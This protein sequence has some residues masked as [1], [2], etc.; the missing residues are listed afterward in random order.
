VAGETPALPKKSPRLDW[1]RL[2]RG[3]F[4]DKLLIRRLFILVLLTLAPLTQAGEGRVIK[5]LP[6]FLD[7]KGEHALSPSLYERD[8]YQFYLRTHPAQCAGL[9][10]AVQWKAQAVDWSQLKLRAEMR[11]LQGDTLHTVTLEEPVLKKGRFSHWSALKIEGADYKS[12]GQLIA[13]R[14]TLWEGQQ[15]LSELKSF[16]WSGVASSP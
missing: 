2:A 9:R 4:A 14:V 5:V 12:F 8:A 10:L 7:R 16:L 15:Q 13:W 1:S 6:Q 3:L 11:G